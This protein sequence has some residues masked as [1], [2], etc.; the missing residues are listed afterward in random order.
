MSLCFYLGSYFI[1]TTS[2]RLFTLNENT[3]VSTLSV[4]GMKL[5]KEFD[6]FVDEQNIDTVCINETVDTFGDGTMYTVLGRWC[7]LTWG[8]KEFLEDCP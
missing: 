7:T 8:I 2:K 4:I 1:I 3:L 5:N 6:N